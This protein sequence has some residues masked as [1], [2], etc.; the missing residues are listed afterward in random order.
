M[1]RSNTWPRVTMSVW[2]Y[3]WAATCPPIRPWTPWCNYPSSHRPPP[4][5]GWGGAPAASPSSRAAT[6]RPPLTSPVTNPPDKPNPNYEGRLSED[7]RTM[8]VLEGQPLSLVVVHRGSRAYSCVWS[9]RSGL[10][11]LFRSTCRSPTSA[12]S[13]GVSTYS[14][15][16]KWLTWLTCV[17][18]L[19]S[20]PPVMLLL[21]SQKHHAACST[22]PP[23]LSKKL[24]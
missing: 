6:P 17:V 7:Y 19:W 14:M 12:T 4:T 3:V 10:P 5:H 1:D 22:H 9:L 2:P 20:L 24:K 23:P 15:F 13:N 18:N 11:P 8:T 16:Q 21:S